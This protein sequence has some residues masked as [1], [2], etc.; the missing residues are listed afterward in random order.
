VLSPERIISDL[1]TDSILFLKAL[2]PGELKVVD[3]GA[4]A[5][6][7]GV[8][9]AIARPEI[10]MTLIESK[11]KR[12]SFLLALRREL[13]V[14]NIFIREGRAEELVK[15][16]RALLG[17]FDVAVTRAAGPA[18]TILPIAMSYLVDG[19]QFVAG[20]SSKS[21]PMDAPRARK[22]SVSV[23]ELGLG[24]T[25]LLASKLP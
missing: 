23:P 18:A 5:G 2:P 4:G 21:V 14:E 3:I 1:F 20:G 17:R 25:L 9:M 19:G 15:V 11:R 6:I 16:D 8:P 24:R 22:E 12:V 10:A 7:P 13:E